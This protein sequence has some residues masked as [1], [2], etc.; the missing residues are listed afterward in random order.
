MRSSADGAI[1]KLTCPTN[2]G[3]TQ[4]QK[5]YKRLRPRNAGT[6][7][8]KK[9]GGKRQQQYTPLTAPK[10]P[11]QQRSRPGTWRHRRD[12]CGEAKVLRH[13]HVDETISPDGGR[14]Y[15]H[16]KKEQQER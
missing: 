11:L 1:L 12:T 16:K 4:V 13:K 5:L 14:L 2:G 6:S 9:R 15:K 3:S 7:R 10:T 8:G